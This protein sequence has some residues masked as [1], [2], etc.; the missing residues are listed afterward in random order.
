MAAK[1]FLNTALKNSVLFV[2]LTLVGTAHTKTIY[3]D[4]DAPADFDN[5]QAA[6]DAAVDGDIIVVGLGIYTGDGNR[7]IDFNGMA[8]IVRSTN[9]N[10]PDIVAA[11]IIDCNGTEEEPHRGFYFHNGEEANSIIAGLTITNGYA[12]AGGAI[13]CQDSRPEITNCTFTSNTSLNGAGIHCGFPLGGGAQSSPE[14]P[15]DFNI[16]GT[17][18]TNCTFTGNSGHGMRIDGSSAIL[19]NCIFTENSDQGLVLVEGNLAVVDCT[20]TAN[21]RGGMLISTCNAILVGSIFKDNSG[22]G[23]FILEGNVTFIDC[24]FTDNR[25]NWQAGGLYNGDSVT[26]LKNC[27][28]TGNFGNN[29][30]GG[31]HNE[32]KSNLTMV[33]CTISGNSAD[34]G[35]GLYNDNKSSAKLTNCIFSD[36]SANQGAGIYTRWGSLELTDCKFN[37]NS[38]D[39]LE[40]GGIY[41][42]LSP[43]PQPISSPGAV[44]LQLS[45]EILSGE[46]LNGNTFTN[47]T[48]TGNSAALGGGIHNL[49]KNL[50]IDNCIFSENSADRGGGMYNT[51]ANPTL[52]NCTFY[53]NTADDGAGLF[54]TYG[55][56]K[57]T[58]CTFTANS[59][60]WR[61]GGMYNIVGS[62]LLKNCIFTGNSADS[63]GGMDNSFNSL[64]LNNCL[65]SGNSAKHAAGIDNFNN[66]L[67]LT[68]CT[69]AGNS[70]GVISSSHHCILDITSCIFWGN[71]GS[72][73]SAVDEVVV[74]V[75]YSDMQ[76]GWPDTGN[77]DTDPMF[78]DP[79]GADDIL[80]TED[81]NLHL[82]PGS[83]CIDTGN[84]SYIAEPNETDLDDRPRII[85]C[86]VDMGVYE[87]GQIVSAQ[88]RIVPR[89][90]NLAS[91]GNWITCYIWLPD[92]YNVADIKPGTVFLECEIK[93]ES[94]HVDEQQQFAT[95]IFSR[96]DVQPI[97]EVGDIDLKITGRLTDGTVFEGTDT[98]KVIDKAGK[99]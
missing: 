54:S 65:F 13:R 38:A 5:I 57:I 10:D 11:T 90:I 18:V 61:G 42:D 89:T 63:G 62:L 98:I 69:F 28:F 56:P 93:L 15:S 78:Q 30:A 85:G 23:A 75:N 74:T 52:T 41:C 32:L 1:T 35:A 25:A 8:I 76:G 7:D 9:A 12:S 97:L 26:T 79:D 20:F 3:V 73:I 96:E 60:Y 2:V 47:C 86:R 39:P 58:N 49:S 17:K 59:A 33:D 27:I 88:A 22:T 80:G 83:P 14:I 21:Q 82:L 44:E 71:A 67:V 72:V 16:P 53:K 81:D 66:N 4:D 92:Q 46:N 77:I 95:A 68:N 84:P 94:L 6:I 31:I 29:R 43:V 40:G 99:N 48:F 91:K 70:V 50:T 55:D 45:K 51:D 24:E 36:N 37:K 19:R 34:V 87:H 64:V